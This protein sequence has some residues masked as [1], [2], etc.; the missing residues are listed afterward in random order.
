MSQ[1]VNIILNGKEVKVSADMTIRQAAEANGNKIPTFCYDERLKPYTSCFLCV[2]EVEGARGMT[3]ACS[4]KVAE[5]MKIQTDSDKVQATRK[6]SLDLVLSDHAGDCIAPCE[7]KCPSNVDIQGYIAHISNGN[8]AAATK[9]IKEQNPLPVVC[10]RICPHP[11]ESQCRRTLVD[12]QAVAINPLKRFASEYELDQGAYL[13][14]VGKDTGKRVAIVGGG[15]AGLTAAYKLR[16]TGHAVDLYDMMPELGGMTR[17]GIPSFR[18]P[19]DKLDNEIK[20]ITDLG[21]N[22]KM[23]SKL[24]RDFT[25]ESLKA[26]GADAVLLA[27]GAF[28][29]KKMWVDN[30]DLP[31]VVGGVDFLGDV[32]LKRHEK[33]GETA[34]VIGGGDTA[35]DCARVAARAGYKTTLLYRRTQEEMPALQHEQDETIGEGVEFKILT[36]PTSVID[37]DGQAVGLTVITMELG[38]PDASGRR[39]PVPVEGSEQ[40]LS[41]DLIIS[42][43]GQDP[44]M[45][46]I[47]NEKE[48]PEV[49]KWSTFVYDEKVKTTTVKGVFAAGDCA[50][51]PDTVIRAIGE[52]KHAAKAIDLFLMGAPIEIKR[53]YEISRG[54]LADLKSEDFSPRWEHKKRSLETTLPADVRMANG[55]YDPINIGFDEATALAES[56]RCIE[57]GCNARFSCDLRDYSTEYDATEKTYAGRKRDYAEDKRHPLIKIEADKC[58]TCGSCVRVCD[59]LRGISAL[60]LENRGFFTKIVPAFGDALQDVGCDACGMC[61]DV[62]PTGAM[63]LNLGKECGPW[64]TSKAITTCTSCTKG[65]ALKVHSKDGVFTKIESVVEDSVNSGVICRDGRFQFQLRDSIT[66]EAA[67]ADSAQVAK[68]AELYSASAKVSVVVSPSMTVEELYAASKMVKGGNLYYMPGDPKKSSDKP[69]SK[70]EASANISLMEKLGAKPFAGGGVDLIVSLGY[71]IEATKTKTISLTVNAEGSADVNLP[72]SSNLRRTGSFL[73][74][75]GQLGRLESDIVANGSGPLSMMAAITGNSSLGDLGAMQTELSSTV[76]ELKDSFTKEGRLS[77]TGLSPKMVDLADDSWTL[78]FSNLISQKGL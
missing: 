54:W 57:C 24:G 58:I 19:W 20:A 1:D 63:A 29:S 73:N 39:R 6:M 47:E 61:H 13:P 17:Y 10:G 71:D 38:E 65:C 62:C 16:Q 46:C 77:D 36:A 12:G 28:K 64:K 49:T 18:L 27:I 75:G 72:L 26:G 52:G 31:G 9:L 32:V 25:I 67:E 41:F 50:F 76:S 5:G 22:I 51:G 35:M 42:A 59:E 15:P 70:I 78:A 34:C 14:P 8:Y 43:I 69:F 74:D 48:K 11:C 56:S 44:D 2:V 37:K 60:A 4:T 23:N 3:P 55:G 21:M 45:S 30:E 7:S 66:G 33:K 53:P 68:A 40:D